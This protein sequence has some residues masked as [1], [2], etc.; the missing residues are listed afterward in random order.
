MVDDYDDLYA[1]ETDHERALT[2]ASFF[3]RALKGGATLVAAPALLELVA[4]C[5]SASSSSTS[6][7]APA[8][9][10][11]LASA[12]KT[13]FTTLY[14]PV[15]G[16]QPAAG[17]TFQV[18]QNLAMTG[19][20]AF[21]GQVMS[22][23]AALASAQI[24][25][26]GGPNFHMNINDHKGLT[27]A[28]VLGVQRLITVDSIHMLETSYAAPT[29]ALIPGL[30]RNQVLTFNGGGASPGQIGKDFVWQTRMLLGW[31]SMPGALAWLH[32][33]FPTL[34]NVA[35]IGTLEN[36]VEAYRKKLPVQWPKLVPGAKVVDTEVH[37]VGETNFAPFI[38]RI[39]AA[40]PD[41][42]YTFSFGNDLG[43][44]I[45]QFRNAGYKG[46][47][48]GN[49]FTID[50]YRIA[51]KDMDNGYFFAYDYFDP[52]NANPLTQQFVA[53]H[54][55]AYGV[56]PEFYGANYYEITL[57]LWELVRRV[58]AKGGNPN[59]GAEL[60]AALE[61]NPKFPSVYGGGA[62][63]VGTI[64]F[65]L[66]KSPISGH[67]VSKPMGVYQETNGVAQLLQFVQRIEFNA[68]PT[69]ALVGPPKMKPTWQLPT[70]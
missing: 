24:K 70:A 34:K 23:G 63:N 1:G 26:F 60:Q 38:D 2:R 22:R 68:N 64:T 53:A 13:V 48:L 67:T 30:Q 14:P 42:V 40:K 56:A 59:S 61:A 37:N 3:G 41:W 66:T 15:N 49:E 58:Q 21:Y 35:V 18:G 6:V 16:A 43:Y 47:I 32:A 27:S 54:K 19:S 62:G 57:L 17:K 11:T 25:A 20:G 10:G 55:K 4:A 46:L 45:K 44:Q 8:S 29:E 39:L 28:S 52:N 65:D 33:T 12:T 7:A 5:G 69:T 51:G 50:A 31:D 9:G 36:G